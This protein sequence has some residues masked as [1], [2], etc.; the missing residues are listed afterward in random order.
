MEQGHLGAIVGR[1][2]RA[3]VKLFHL[4]ISRT[5]I[6]RND[7]RAVPLALRMRHGL[8]LLYSIATNSH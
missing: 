6:R 4:E 7:T 2:R 8:D 3:K 1:Q 5:G